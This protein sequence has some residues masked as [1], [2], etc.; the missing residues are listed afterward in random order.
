MFNYNAEVF[1][2]VYPVAAGGKFLQMVM[3]LDPA[4]PVL[5]HGQLK[6]THDQIINYLQTNRDAHV[7]E[8]Q[9]SP[10]YIESLPAASKYVFQFHPETLGWED[11]DSIMRKCTKL[12]PIFITCG[13]E[14]SRRLVNHRRLD[15][16][17]LHFISSTERAFNNFLPHIGKLCWSADPAL[18]IEVEDYWNPDTAKPM[19]NDF[20]NKYN[21]ITPGWEELYDVWHAS[22]IAPSL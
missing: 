12:R 13:R 19:L 7:A 9:Q 20:F 11:V 17:N 5:V 3:H 6:P 1:V 14:A 15:K 21:I 2:I 18:V 8:N 10:A 16:Q 4:M 22:S